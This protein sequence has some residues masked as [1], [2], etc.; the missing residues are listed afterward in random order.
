M[1]I[2][3]FVILLL[4]KNK[5]SAYQMIVLFDYNN[6]LFDTKRGICFIEKK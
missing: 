2:H 1:L 3:A 4:Y 5:Y 6:V